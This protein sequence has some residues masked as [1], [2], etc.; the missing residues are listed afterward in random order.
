M[1]KS[2]TCLFFA[3]FLYNENYGQEN[4]SYIDSIEEYVQYVDSIIAGYKTNPASEKITTTR[5]SFSTIE[6]DSTKAKPYCASAEV[7]KDAES[8]VVY[9]LYYGNNCT[10]EKVEHLYYFKNDKIVLLTISY[11]GASDKNIR[12]YYLK[13]ANIDQKQIDKSYIQEGYNL[14]KK[15]DY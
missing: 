8:K 15:V 3:L 4:K 2:I 13:D 12:H 6:T 1:L 14:L 11:W 7:Y 10:D 5:T 9:K